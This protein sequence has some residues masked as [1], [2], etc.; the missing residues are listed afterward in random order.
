MKPRSAMLAFNLCAAARRLGGVPVSPGL[1]DL[2]LA[3]ADRADHDAATDVAAAGVLRR[4]GRP[5]D[6]SDARLPIEQ[7]SVI[8]VPREGPT[9]GKRILLP[10]AAF[11]RAEES[12]ANPGLR[13]RPAG[14]EDP[15]RPRLVKDVAPGWWHVTEF[16]ATK[17]RRHELSWDVVPE[18]ALEARIR[19]RWENYPNCPRHDGRA[20]PGR[21]RRL[22]GTPRHRRQRRHRG[23][24]QRPS[25]ATRSWS[26][27]SASLAPSSPTR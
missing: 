23:F 22:R 5:A 15:S 9:A 11:D 17:V 10:A 16:S 19:P 20:Q 27:C 14:R 4:R 25:C 26:A 13:E 8:V 3:E 6:G 7:P 12:R 2:H 18:S 21:G 1:D 24:V